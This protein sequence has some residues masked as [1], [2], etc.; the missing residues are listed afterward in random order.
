MPTGNTP[1]SLDTFINNV[2]VMNNP[3]NTALEIYYDLD[4][5]IVDNNLYYAVGGD[6]LVFDM[7]GAWIESF[8]D[9]QSD[10]YEPNSLNDDPDFV[11]AN[12]TD[13]YPGAGSPLVDAGLPVTTGANKDF[14]GTSTPQGSAMDIGAV[15]RVQ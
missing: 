13:Y 2:C 5:P 12:G 7:D 9:Y 3:G 14:L 10:G 6:G 8:A 15:E 4:T 11:T 1:P